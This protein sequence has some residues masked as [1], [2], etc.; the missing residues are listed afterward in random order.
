NPLQANELWTEHVIAEVVGPMS[1]DVA[2]MD[3]DGDPDVVVGEHN[4]AEPE[5]ARLL[6]F[7]NLDGSGKLWKGYVVHTGDEH[8][9]GA[10]TVDIDSDGDLD[11]I[12]IGWSHPRVLLYENLAL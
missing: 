2:D 9:D 1:L 8:H 11:I 12:S 7:Q 5:T 4:Y 6:I 3:D 10:I